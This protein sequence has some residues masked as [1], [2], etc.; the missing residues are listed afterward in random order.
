MSR[1]AVHTVSR[2]T[3]AF[4]GVRDRFDLHPSSE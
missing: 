2:D 1:G 3:V 4:G